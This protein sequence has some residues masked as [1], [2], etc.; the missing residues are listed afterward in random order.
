MK[1]P[2]PQNKLRVNQTECIRILTDDTEDVLNMVN[3]EGLTVEVK[4]WQD[5]WAKESLNTKVE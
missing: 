1:M 4:S 3:G 5:Y 2:N